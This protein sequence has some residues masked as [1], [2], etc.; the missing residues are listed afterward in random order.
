M[1]HLP[2]K[3]HKTPCAHIQPCM[4]SFN[5]NTAVKKTN[6][7][8]RARVSAFVV[9]SLRSCLSSSTWLFSKASASKCL[10]YSSMRLYNACDNGIKQLPWEKS[11]WR[12][13]YAKA[14]P[15]GRWTQEL[16]QTVSISSGCIA[17]EKCSDAAFHVHVL[18][19]WE[20]IREGSCVVLVH[21]YHRSARK[22]EIKCSSSISNLH[23]VYIRTLYMACI[24][25][26]FSSSMVQEPTELVCMF[27]LIAII[28]EN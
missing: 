26:L 1:K 27:F 14:L 3:I 22:D 2:Q 25:F 19:S 5:L 7:H 17:S 8:W 23:L 16:S 18:F 12:M 6:L 9:Y 28:E 24:Y 4:W 20:K 11:V 21:N 15:M 13:D 10:D